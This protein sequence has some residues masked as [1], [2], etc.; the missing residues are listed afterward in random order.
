MRLIDIVNEGGAIDMMAMAKKAKAL[1]A[2]GMSEQQAQDALVK[3][4]V[5]ARLAAQA[6]QMVSLGPWRP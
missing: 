5:P 1:L 4:G 6:V 2:Q 3:Q